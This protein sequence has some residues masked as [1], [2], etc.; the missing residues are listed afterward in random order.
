M[1]IDEPKT[2]YCYVLGKFNGSQGQRISQCL[3]IS[4]R[5]HFLLMAETILLVL[6][7]IYAIEAGVE[8]FQYATNVVSFFY[9]NPAMWR[10]HLQSVYLS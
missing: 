7:V 8:H 2:R 6:I 9:L 3:S 1:N 10:N 5:K 4:L